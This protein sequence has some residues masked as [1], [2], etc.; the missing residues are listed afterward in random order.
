[1]SDLFRNPPTDSVENSNS[2]SIIIRTSWLYSSNGKNFVNTDYINSQSRGY[3]GALTV[4]ITV[5]ASAYDVKLY[6]STEDAGSL[7]YLRSSGHDA[8]GS[9]TYTH[10]SGGTLDTTYT[11]GA[12]MACYEIQG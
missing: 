7:A 3:F 12:S 2:E 6:Y 8:N 9:D 11:V 10:N 1:M 5:A 4:D